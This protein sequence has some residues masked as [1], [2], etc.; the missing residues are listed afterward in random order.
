MKYMILFVVLLC[1]VVYV[2]ATDKPYKLA[3]VHS[4]SLKN[5][6]SNNEFK[7]E[8][9]YIRSKKQNIIINS[10]YLN[11]TK[12]M[13]ETL[14]HK[15]SLLISNKIKELEPNLVIVYNN[16]AFEHI[17]LKYLYSYN[18]NVLIY[19]ATTETVNKLVSDNSSFG[20]S[21]LAGI[22]NSSNI[23]KLNKIFNIIEADSYYIIKNNGK[24]FEIQMK[25]LLPKLQPNKYEVYNIDTLL[26]LRKTLEK[27]DNKPMGIIIFFNDELINTEHNT[28]A[29]DAEIINVFKHRNTKHFEICMTKDL[30]EHGF[31]SSSVIDYRGVN[32]YIDTPFEKILS[33]QLLTKKAI[34]RE[35]FKIIEFNQKRLEELNFS[36][37]LN[38]K[39][40]Y[41]VIY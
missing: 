14:L 33:S 37:L 26:D 25:D 9:D 28:I 17:A 6:E 18:M 39:N 13:P 35:E 7:N 38:E 4:Y 24:Y 19:G 23:Y 34:F 40:L 10:Y 1:Y 36:V 21:K 16:I 22:V 11:Y 32:S 12:G 20:R 31:C 27:I 2:Y 30:S 41:S 29:T 5:L 8:I 15:N 3:I